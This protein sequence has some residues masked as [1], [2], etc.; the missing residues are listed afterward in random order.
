MIELEKNGNMIRSLSEDS[1]WYIKEFRQITN[2]NLVDG[3]QIIGDKDLHIE[4]E[5]NVFLFNVDNLTI[6]GLT[7]NNSQEL[8]NYLL[9]G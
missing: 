1:Y 2:Q 4:L 6:G 3:F 5:G 9:N 7:F 8:K